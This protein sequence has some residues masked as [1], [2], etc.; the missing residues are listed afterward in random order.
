MAFIDYEDVLESERVSDADNILRIHGVHPRTMR[1]H[2]D[3]YR[4]LLYAAGPLGRIQREMIY[5]V[6]EEV[7]PES[8]RDR[9]SFCFVVDSKTIIGGRGRLVLGG[10]HP[11]RTQVAD[12]FFE[13]RVQIAEGDLETHYV[14]YKFLF[15]K[16]F[17]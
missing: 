3:L 6:V 17:Y 7:I 1:L 10:F 2:Y 12:L 14:Y 8:Q 15:T 13:R 5:I 11:N 4:E 16:A 9:Y